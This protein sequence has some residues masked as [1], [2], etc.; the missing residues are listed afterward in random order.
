MSRGGR[1]YVA[2]E[3]KRFPAVFYFPGVLSRFY[4]VWAESLAH[5]VNSNVERVKTIK[6]GPP[7]ICCEL[8][9]TPIHQMIVEWWSASKVGCSRKW[10]LVL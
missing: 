2:P 7:E 5:P 8:K 9:L 3:D 6:K 4:M 1:F 10:D